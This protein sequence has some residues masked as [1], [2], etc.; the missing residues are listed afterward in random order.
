MYQPKDTGVGRLHF[1]FLAV[2]SP[3]HLLSVKYTKL[4]QRKKKKKT[5]HI[6]PFFFG[7]API[8]NEKILLIS[9]FGASS[10]K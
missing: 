3:I 6:R 2:G 8:E 9:K 4:K 7:V 1:Q 5:L 10:K